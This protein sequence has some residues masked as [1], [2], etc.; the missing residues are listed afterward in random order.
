[1]TPGRPSPAAARSLT[2]SSP[3]KMRQCASRPRSACS[4]LYTT[5]DSAHADSRAHGSS[6]G[7]AASRSGTPAPVSADPAATGTS[8]QRRTSARAE[9]RASLALT[10]APPETAGPPDAVASSAA[11]ASS[12][13]VGSARAAR[14]TRSS[15]AASTSITRGSVSGTG[16]V[17]AAGAPGASTSV[18]GRV[19]T[20]PG[21]VSRRPISPSTRAGSAPP[22]SILLM[23]MS[24]GT[25]KRRSARQ[26][27]TVCDWTPSTADTT[28]TAAS[29]TARLRSTSAMKSEWPGVSMRLT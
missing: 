1:M 8:W 4:I 15:S 5:P 21:A 14:S 11:V 22:R 19:C 13:M 2:R 18:S 17:P 9:R 26:R 12:E 27:T 16:R 23:K 20:R 29:S 10:V 25:A 3:P 7:S 24:V 28:R 6:V